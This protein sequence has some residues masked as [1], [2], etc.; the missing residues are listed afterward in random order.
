L[1]TAI[2]LSGGL[3]TENNVVH[4]TKWQAFGWGE[5]E[6]RPEKYPWKHDRFF[7]SFDYGSLRRGF[8][9]YRQ[10]CSTCHS[11]NFMAYRCLVGYTHTLVQARAL[12]ATIEVQDGPDEKGQMYMRPGRI[13]DKF[14]APYANEEI[15]RMVNGGALPPDL[16]NAVKGRSHA[17]ED[18]IF[19]LLTGYKD[20]PAGVVLRPGLYWNRSFHG[21]AIAMPPPLT[22]GQLDYEDGT[23]AT[24]TQMA[25]DVSNFLTFCSHPTQ[26]YRKK[27]GLGALIPTFFTFFTTVWFKR[28]K[29][30]IFK[31]RRVSWMDHK[32]THLWKH[33]R[34]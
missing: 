28:F 24:A 14:K 19:S 26:D 3:N 8:E 13:S 12:A 11:M 29:W 10:I 31:S 6:T 25:Y 15:A 33:Q 22:D 16:S 17:R 1:G 32:W 20:P 34:Y 9:V 7:G 18:F 27:M 21:G 23:P 30:Q 5:P 4:A 2:G